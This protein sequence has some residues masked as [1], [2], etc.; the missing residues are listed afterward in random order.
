MKVNFEEYGACFSISLVPE[1]ADEVIDL[2][3]LG[4]LHTKELRSVN[5]HMPAK[6]RAAGSSRQPSANIVL[7]KI[8]NDLNH[9]PKAR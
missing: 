9:V 8:K 6:Q 3:R 7:G 5:V 2:V 4:M 1:T